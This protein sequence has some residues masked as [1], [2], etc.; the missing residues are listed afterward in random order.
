MKS[1]RFGALSVLRHP[2]ALLRFLRSDEESLVQ[3]LAALAAILYVVLPLDLIPDTI[4]LIGWLDDIGVVALVLGWTA[5]RVQ[6]YVDAPARTRAEVTPP[7][8]LEAPADFR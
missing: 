3:R 1:K 5:T 2:R 7:R 4:P 8:Q 6:R